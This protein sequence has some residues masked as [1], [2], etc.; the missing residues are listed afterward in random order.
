MI[1]ARLQLHRPVEPALHIQ[2]QCTHGRH[3]CFLLRAGSACGTKSNLANTYQTS[4]LQSLFSLD[5][6]SFNTDQFLL[7][8]IWID[9]KLVHFI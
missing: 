3:H 2:I 1:V 6:R 4:H 7:D 8:L 5:E 9:L